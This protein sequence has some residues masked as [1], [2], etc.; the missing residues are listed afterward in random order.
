MDELFAELFG[1]DSN[2]AIN[3]FVSGLEEVA[4]TK[5][6]D[7][8]IYVASI[9]AHYAQTSRCDISSMP[10]LANLSEVHDEFVLVQINDPEILEIGGSQT[11]LFAGFFRDQ[12]SLRHNVNWFD[13]LGQSFY[14]RAS[15]SSREA[16]KRELLEKMAESF[17]VWAVRC[18]DLHRYYRDNRYLIKPN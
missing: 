8:M 6:R 3:F 7:E 2:I 14:S 15:V 17:P 4:D 11:L 13:S 1:V 12:M 9:L 10:V 16:K 18:R 5:S